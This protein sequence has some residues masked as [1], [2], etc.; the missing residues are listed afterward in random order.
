MH[1]EQDPWANVSPEVC[2]EA[3]ELAGEVI[4]RML[5]WTADAP[6]MLDRGLRATVALHCL[7][8]D[9]IGS[10]TLDRI[11]DQAARTRQ[12]V[13]TLSKEFKILM[14]ESGQP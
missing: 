7:R 9:L 5:V 3:Q 14:G 8:P 12:Y 4:R 10:P 2:A 6:T 1:R 13:H 11:G